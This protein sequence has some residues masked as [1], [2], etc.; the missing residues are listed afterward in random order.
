M[1][2]SGLPLFDKVEPVKI[3][4]YTVGELTQQIKGT[5]EPAFRSIWVQGEVSNYRPAA[6]GHLYFSLK[7]TDASISVAMFNGSRRSAGAASAVSKL[8]DGLQVLC[9]GKLSVYSPRGSYQLVIE[10]IQLVGEG[11]LQLAFEQ[12]KERLLKEGLFSPERKKPLPPYPKKIAII[13]SPTGAAVRDMLNVLGRRAPHLKVTVVPAVV[14]GDDAPRQIIRAMDQAEKFKLGDIIVLARGGGSIEDLWAFNDE[15]LARRIFQCSIPVISAIG[16]EI[17]FTISD[18]VADLRAPTPSAGAE[19]LSAGWMNIREKL[20]ESNLRLIQSTRRT[21]Q[22][23]NQNLRHL[24]ARLI[25]PRD[26]LR[27]QSQKIDDLSQRLDLAMKS[28]LSRLKLVLESRMAKLDALSPLRVL[29]RGY[30]IVRDDEKPDVLI[31]SAAQVQ[32]GKNLRITFYDG[33]SKVRAL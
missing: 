17:D 20:I 33:E 2:Y 8:K 15:T 28:R 27:E 31:Q 10:E 7:D 11:A 4:H 12:L 16:H 3:H 25:S 24:S 1:D 21:L 14:Q 9:R 29:E 13:T 30:S 6:S 19:I 23:L 18:F 22:H 26:R 32:S 5:L